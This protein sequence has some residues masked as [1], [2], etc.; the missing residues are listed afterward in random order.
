MFFKTGK[1]WDDIYGVLDYFDVMNHAPNVSCPVIMG[2]GLFDETCPPAINFSAY[3]NLET[4][5]KEYHLYPQSGHSLPESHYG[6]KMKWLYERFG[7]GK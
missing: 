5:D 3:N 4:Q 2:V 1:K 6:V 7:I